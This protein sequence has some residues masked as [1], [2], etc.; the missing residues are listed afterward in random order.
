LK[1]RKVTPHTRKLFLVAERLS[2]QD[3]ITSA[4]ERNLNEELNWAVN[5]QLGI[6]DPFVEDAAQVLGGKHSQLNTFYPY[7]N[8]YEMKLAF[9]YIFMTEDINET[10]WA[11]WIGTQLDLQKLLGGGDEKST[12]KT[13]KMREDGFRVLENKSTRPKTPEVE[14]IDL[15]DSPPPQSKPTFGMPTPPS[16]LTKAGE[17]IRGPS[18]PLNH[19]TEGASFARPPSPPPY[20]DQSR[21][22]ASY[23]TLQDFYGLLDKI[24]RTSYVGAMFLEAYAEKLRDD[25]CKDCWLKRNINLDLY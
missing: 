11:L 19:H 17:S 7:Q 25:L 5:F 4:H 18:T 1:E 16:S 2:W 24:E 22:I 6:L 3:G 23:K 13:P 15:T 8:D 9:R 10:T 21:R 14:T 12:H 20:F